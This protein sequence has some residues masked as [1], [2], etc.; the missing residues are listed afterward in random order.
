MNINIKIV[1]EYFYPDSFL[2]NDITKELVDKGHNVS[3][4]TGLPD[5]STG[6]IPKEFRF[7]KNRKQ[8]LFG[9]KVRRIPMIARHRG[10]AFRILN[11]LSFMINSTVYAIFCSKKKTDVIFVYETSPVFQALA[12]VILKKRTGRKLVMYC[13]DLWPESIKAWGIKES[14][15]IFKVVKKFSSW[16]YRKCDVVAVTSKPFKDY[17]IHICGVNSDR[18]EYLPQYAED[19]YTDIVGNCTENDCVDFMFA[20][21]I[22]S[23]QNVDCII[24]AVKYIKTDKNYKIHIVGD[25]SEFEKIKKMAKELGVSER[26]DFHGRFPRSQMSE[27]YKLADCFLL[28]LNGDNF[29]GKT[30]PGKLQSYF[31]AGKPVIA[32]IDGAAS[33]IIN[34]A[35]AGIAVKAG[36]EQSL[37]KAMQNAVENFSNF[38][39][40]GNNARLYYEKNFTKDKFIADLL[41]I[42]LS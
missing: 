13:C 25:G 15:L 6:I 23:V 16:L 7:F 37:A 28:T 18:I 38:N 35:N 42:L 10:V 17:L 27:F 32:A 34:E 19:L 26:I 12:A 3:V 11:Y 40:M 8:T 14:S 29:I 2:I 39:E 24:N 41:K 33:D 5:Y 22:G 36:D 20:G 9:A 4:I 30:I 21:N 31:S 1:S